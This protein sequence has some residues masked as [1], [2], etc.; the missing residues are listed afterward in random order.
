MPGPSSYARSL[1]AA[2]AL[3]AMPAPGAFA[4]CATASLE[5]TWDMVF[6]STTSADQKNYWCT[7]Q[8][9]FLGYVLN[10]TCQSGAPTLPLALKLRQASSCKV[11]SNDIKIY[12]A[13]EFV[14]S[15]STG[16]PTILMLEWSDHGKFSGFR[17]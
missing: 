3:L 5:G 12:G 17:R 11:R 16:K 1:A 7:I 4:A 10:Q 13:T 2:F 9:S 14:P 8:F 15:T 6:Q